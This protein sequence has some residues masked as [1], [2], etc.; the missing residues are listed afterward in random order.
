MFRPALRKFSFTCLS[1]C[2]LLSVN[3]SA[4]ATTNAVLNT[5][6]SATV[7]NSLPYWILHSNSG[8]TI[9]CTAI[10]GQQITLATVPLVA[11][12]QDILTINGAGV[13]VDGA[14]TFQ[15]FSVGNGSTT[16]NNF[17]V[18]NAISK[19]GNGGTAWVGGGGGVGGGGALYVHTGTKV[20]INT[21][22]MIGNLAAGGNGGNGDS[23]FT[24]ISMGGGGGGFGGGNGGIGGSAS[25]AGC[26]GGG[27]GNSGGGAG[28]NYDSTPGANGY[29]YSGGGGGG[30]NNTA[31]IATNGGS[32]GNAPVYS[33]GTAGAS[34]GPADNGGGGGGAGIGGGTPL[35][36]GTGFD[37]SD[38]VLL[39]E[40][41]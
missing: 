12:M 20:T 31:G 28:A 4:L 3:A 30:S 36:D 17:N 26:G 19:G 10:A 5:N 18:Q 40:K 14:N 11:I 25:I 1:S 13:T 35:R 7:V 21:V 27:G 2:L 23:S 6:E 8:D 29:Y 41:N 34:T 38:S 9:D 39:E 37:G 33:G 32:A 16:I 22:S 24:Y 15:A